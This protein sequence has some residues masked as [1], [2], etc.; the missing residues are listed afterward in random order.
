MGT[1]GERLVFIENESFSFVMR[2][3]VSWEV[4]AS[5]GFTCRL[6]ICAASANSDPDRQRENIKEEE[7]R[8][9]KKI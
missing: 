7:R 5:K 6:L 3:S 9:V 8:K 4:Q 2:E 1:G